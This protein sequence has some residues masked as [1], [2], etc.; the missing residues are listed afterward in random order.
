[1]INN[2]NERVF[3]EAM[4]YT[5]DG[6]SPSLAIE[7]QEKREQQKVVRNCRL[8]KK[9]DGGIPD[10]CKNKGIPHWST[11]EWDQMS[12]E[13][14]DAICESNKI[15][16]VKQQYAKMGIKILGEVDDLFYSVEL[17]EGWK[18]K[19]TNHSM[20]NDVLDNNGHKRIS[21][22]YKGAFYD[23]DA[24]S[25]FERRY[26]YSI[27]PFDFY[28]TDASYE[29]RESKPWS[30]YLTDGGKRV[31]LLKT[32]VPIVSQRSWELDD[33]LRVCAKTYLNEHYPDWEDIDAY[34]D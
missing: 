29:E 25:N 28:E 2:D 10:E 11:P 1:M 33:A 32:L 9:V 3:L 30:A 21:F 5:M 22:F 13:E 27:C 6:K 4:L 18:I 26:G 19:A 16:W 12:W 24:F 34:W 15:E 20:W 7:D 31:E 17:P 14:R 8:P 23:R